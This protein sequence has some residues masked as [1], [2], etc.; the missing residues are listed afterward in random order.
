M[1]DRRYAVRVIYC[2][3]CWLGL[4]LC[5]VMLY[6]SVSYARMLPE[7]WA[8]LY[9]MWEYDGV[10]PDRLWDLRGKAFLWIG[11]NPVLFLLAAAAC[12]ASTYGLWKRKK[13]STGRT[14]DEER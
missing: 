1:R 6:A 2:A 8:D 7:W 10:M 12:G 5:G 14:P 13:E 3:I 9:T 11:I 4:M